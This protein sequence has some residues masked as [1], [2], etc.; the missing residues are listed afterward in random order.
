M[1]GEIKSLHVYSIY[2]L[3]VYCSKITLIMFLC[4]LLLVYILVL[5]YL[6]CLF[7]QYLHFFFIINFQ[8]NVGILLFFW[9][10]LEI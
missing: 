9:V 3:H 7:T 4:P 5:V 1:V 6:L 8:Y 2:N 10:K